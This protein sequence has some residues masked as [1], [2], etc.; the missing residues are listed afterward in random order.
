VSG[1]AGA[2]GTLRRAILGLLLLALAGT[3]I[4]LLLLEHYE[5]AWQL[6]PLV[7][8]GLGLAVTGFRLF[9]PG[10]GLRAFRGV[11]L[12]MVA[13]GALGLFLH[14]RGNVE[15]ELEREPMLG[16]LPLFREAM[17]G[18]TPALAPGAMMLFGLLGLASAL[19]VGRQP[20]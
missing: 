4:E 19:Q 20:G 16:G 13:S 11:M 8:I 17:T 12:L 15:F 18:A 14:Y 10:S 3:G 2:E 5:D 6:V 7:F 9:R 1:G